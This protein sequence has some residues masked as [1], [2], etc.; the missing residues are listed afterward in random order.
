[1]TDVTKVLEGTSPVLLPDFLDDPG[2]QAAYSADAVAFVTSLGLDVVAGGGP[3]G[4]TL[5][6]PLTFD[7]WVPSKKVGIDVHDLSG[8]RPAIYDRGYLRG[9]LVAAQA[10]GVRYVQFFSDEWV[11]KAAI[12]RSIAANALGATAIRLHARHCDIVVTT[13][14]V[15]K[16]QLNEMHLQGATRAWDHLVLDH[17]E[18]GALGPVGIV[19]V[20]TPI[21]KKYGH[22]CELARLALRPGISV[23][24]GPSKMLAVAHQR[25]KDKGFSAVLS[26]S[27][28]RIGTGGVYL[29]CGYKL[30]GETT[31]NYFYSDGAVRY[32]RFKYRAQPGKP[33]RVV[34]AEA[35]VRPVWGPGHRIYLL[36]L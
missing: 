27:D 9:R 26:Y 10:A 16:P 19:T 7:A 17:V 5:G 8:G 13:S 22:V 36:D 23:R 4:S 12:C 35:G 25:A 20:R 15:T 33:E 28:L 1:M 18:H 2:V 32:D 29:Q 11:N 34:V 24:G 30:V 6:L 14:A 21:Q 31:T 3:S